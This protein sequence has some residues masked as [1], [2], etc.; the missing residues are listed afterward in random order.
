MGTAWDSASNVDKEPAITS[1][2]VLR[3]I[4]DHIDSAAQP[5]CFE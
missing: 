2:I 4:G 1:D 5:S 3:T